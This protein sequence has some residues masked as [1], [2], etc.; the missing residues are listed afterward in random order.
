MGAAFAGAPDSPAQ[1][2]LGAGPPTLK[3][4]KDEADPTNPRLRLPRSVANGLALDF[5]QPNDAGGTMFY[6][7]TRNT[8]GLGLSSPEFVGGMV[9]PLSAKWF[10]SLETSVDAKVS[11]T[12]ASPLFGSAI[13]GAPL[14][15]RA[16]ALYPP[17]A[18]TSA[19]AGYELRLNYRYGE[20]NTLGLTSGSVYEADYAR[21][22]PGAQPGEGRQFGLTGEHWLTPEWALNYGVMAQQQLGPHRGQGLRL[23]L[24]Y[25]F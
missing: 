8:G 3:A 25:R 17:A 21:L 5:V 10:S 9:Y 14:P 6:G 24:R 1:L 16:W 23:G 15:E 7:G 19:S 20:R 11:E 13:D 2:G 4:A 22:F 12:A 18:G